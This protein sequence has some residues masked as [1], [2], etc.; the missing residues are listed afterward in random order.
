MVGTPAISGGKVYFPS[1]RYLVSAVQLNDASPIP[2]FPQASGSVGQTGNPAV[3]N[4]QVIAAPSACCTA[5]VYS[6]SPVTGNLQWTTSVQAP[7]TGSPV[8]ANGLVFVNT[9][10]TLYVLSAVTGVVIWS[11]SVPAWPET[12][13]VVAEGIVYLNLRDGYLYAYSEH[14]VAPSARLPGGQMGVKPALSALK[15]DLRLKAAWK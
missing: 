15:P 12:S 10:N 3:G 11:A 2:G 9:A 14:G 13:P 8:L 4:G 5:Q 6:F 1:H 7:L